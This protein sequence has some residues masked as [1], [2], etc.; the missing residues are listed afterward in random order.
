MVVAAMGVANITPAVAANNPPP[1]LQHHRRVPRNVDD[2]YART[3]VTTALRAADSN[4]A[5]R[6]YWA[7]LLNR[8]WPR[9]W[10]TRGAGRSGAAP[11]RGARFALV[12]VCT[13][14]RKNI[15]CIRVLP[16][17]LRRT[18]I[19]AG[20]QTAAVRQAAHRPYHRLSHPL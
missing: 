13:W 17:I 20:R 2:A 4:A 16:A 7:T 11:T 3:R 5:A 6:T 15:P 12:I 14:R 8:A 9:R 18:N 1:A 19:S 10:R